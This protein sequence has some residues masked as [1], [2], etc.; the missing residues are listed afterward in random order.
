MSAYTI[1]LTSKWK[2][3]DL[4]SNKVNDCCAQSFF[5]WLFWLV[6]FC[7]VLFRLFEMLLY[8][9]LTGMS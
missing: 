9:L 7:F 4:I 1:D 2:D 5:S 6:L 8:A 3:G